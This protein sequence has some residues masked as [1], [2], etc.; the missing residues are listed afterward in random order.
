MR[1]YYNDDDLSN[2]GVTV[3]FP[4]WTVNNGQDD[5]KWYDTKFENYSS[6]NCKVYWT[7]A[8]KSDHNNETGTYVTHIYRNDTTNIG[9]FTYDI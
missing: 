6:R 7:T 2:A 1:H 4:T 3:R 5:I 9:E 8:Y